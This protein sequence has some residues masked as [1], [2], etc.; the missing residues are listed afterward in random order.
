[1]T[2]QDFPSK[3]QIL[4]YYVFFFSKLTFFTMLKE[5][6]VLLSHRRESHP[7]IPIGGVELI[8]SHKRFFYFFSADE[9]RT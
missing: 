6:K 5:M 3:Q 9:I 7:N 1:M 8:M 4:F 2:T